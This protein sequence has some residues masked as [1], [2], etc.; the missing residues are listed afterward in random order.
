MNRTYQ[1][2]LFYRCKEGGTRH[3]FNTQAE[4]SSPRNA[5]HR[6]LARLRKKFPRWTIEYTGIYKWIRDEEA[7]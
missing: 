2:R 5:A 6:V 4:G 3:A 1:L 7:S